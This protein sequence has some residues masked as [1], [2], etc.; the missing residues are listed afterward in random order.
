MTPMRASAPCPQIPLHPRL[1][2]EPELTL[3]LI[4]HDGNHVL[5][6]GGS[7]EQRCRCT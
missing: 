3:L 4:V 6:S 1:L 2:L 7:Q 5:Y